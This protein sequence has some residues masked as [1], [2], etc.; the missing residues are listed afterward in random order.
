MVLT[1]NSKHEYLPAFT[2]LLLD[3]LRK[4]I[5]KKK[6][7]TLFINPSTNK[8]Q[9]S[10]CFNENPIL[11]ATEEER[12]ECYK[13]ADAV[14]R[15]FQLAV[16]FAHYSYYNGNI[17]KLSQYNIMMVLILLSTRLIV[18]YEALVLLF[19]LCVRI[20]QFQCFDMYY[21]VL[22]SYKE[23]KSLGIHHIYHDSKFITKI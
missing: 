8:C 16:H 2:A 5:Q 12:K 14:R 17:P 7:Y 4:L 23:N 13:L 22:N 1:L 11:H 6:S 10:I 3:S 18:I 20:L 9:S 19:A 15:T 21:E